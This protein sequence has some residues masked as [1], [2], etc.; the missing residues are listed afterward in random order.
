MTRVMPELA[1]L[2]LQA[3]QPAGRI[4]VALQAYA[5][6]QHS[7]GACSGWAAAQAPAQQPDNLAIS[8]MLWQAE[9]GHAFHTAASGLL[10]KPAKVE[11]QLPGRA[12]RLP[13]QTAM[14]W[15]QMMP[16]MPASACVA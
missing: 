8:S 2:M 10:A 13:A 14:T 11:P 15:S 9:Q 7:C 12:G 4:P 3:V 16:M 1:L 6:H 5:A